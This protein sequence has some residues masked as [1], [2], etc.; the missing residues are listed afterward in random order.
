MFNNSSK[1]ISDIDS[2]TSSKSKQLGIDD[3]TEMS[4]NNNAKPE[5]EENK[6]KKISKA[7]NW[8]GKKV[9]PRYFVKAYSLTAKAKLDGINSYIKKFLE[10]CKDIYIIIK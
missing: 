3:N 1:S 9:D 2:K 4:L 6:K 7:E 5:T 8:E 10:K